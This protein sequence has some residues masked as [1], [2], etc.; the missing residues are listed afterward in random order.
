MISLEVEMVADSAAVLTLPG[1]TIDEIEEKSKLQKSLRRFDLVFFLICTLVGLDTI[2]AVAKNGAQGFTWLV[3]LGIFFFVPYGLLMA[4][5]GSAF[6]FE[7]GPYVWSRLAFGRLVAAIVT[8]LYWLSNPIWLGGTLTILAISAFGDFFT[9]LHG[10]GKLLFA[11]VFIWFAVVSAIVSFRL[12]KWIPSIGAFVRVGVLGF[13]TLSVLLY[14]AHNGVH[15]FGASAFSPGYAVFIAAVPVL[16]FNYVGFELPSSASEEMVDP[17]KDVPR[18]IAWSGLGAILLY[19]IP[20]LAILLI[21]PASKVTGVGGFLDAIKQVFTVYG[22]SVAADGTVTLTGAGKVLG[23]LGAIAFIWALLSSGTT[24]IMGADRTQAAAG[25]DGSAPRPLGRI[26]RRFGTPLTVNVLT[27]IFSTIVMLLA[28]WLSG[29]NAER[30]F[31]AVLGLAIS[32]TTISYL[33]I[34]PA[35]VRLRHTQPEAPR[36]YRVPG[37]TAGVWIVTVLST[38]WALVAT[39][40]LLW[41]GFGV[42]WFGTG[43][44]PDDSL[45]AGIGRGAFELTQILPLLVM[46]AVGVVFY[47]AG[48]PTRAHRASAAEVSAAD[49]RGIGTAP[50]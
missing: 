32:T 4:E 15:G 6:P 7:G 50:G 25:F 44:N 40:S 27:G 34:F 33:G 14:A 28:F 26:N 3:F 38:L 30:Y 19:G 42:G 35:L 8:V 41:P 2:G 47:L 43:G 21:L 45:P 37:G 48:A 36:P 9:P 12:G 17:R 23:D 22:G 20:I 1:M 5:L 46:I 31:A 13:F 16:I 39:I 29:G 18:T 24:W 10:F 49:Q 11:L